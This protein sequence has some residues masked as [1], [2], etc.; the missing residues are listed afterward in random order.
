VNPNPQ[1][2]TTRRNAEVHHDHRDVTG[3]RLRPAVF[4]AMDGLVSNFALMSGVAGGS[5]GAAPVVLAGL[6]GL[7]SGAF[8][9]AVG[10][11]T[12]VAAQRELALAEIEIERRELDASP[13]AELDE[14][15]ALYVARG[16]D[17]PLA[18]QV[19][20]QL[21]RDPERALEIHVRE[22]MGLDAADLPSPWT[23]AT[24]SLAAFSLGALVPLLPYLFGAQDLWPAAVFALVGLFA[25]G[26]VASRVTSRP[27]WYTGTRQVLL[28][29][30]AAGVTYL[31]GS[32]VGSF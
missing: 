18:A 7:A 12:S 2:P 4:G 27:W 23:A 28:G 14:L 19:A 26:V 20:E 32:W 8:S 29:A 15:T 21:S 9:M 31:V 11:Y 22:E 5:T 16:L 13:A 30:A 10:E 24:A 25:T 6:A 17:R 3:G 1:D